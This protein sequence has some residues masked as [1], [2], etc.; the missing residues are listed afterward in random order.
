MGLNGSEFAW[1]LEACQVQDRGNQYDTSGILIFL[2]KAQ[3][4]RKTHVF[5][6]EDRCL[7]L[8]SQFS[9]HLLS[10]SVTQEVIKI[11]IA[12]GFF[13]VKWC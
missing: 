4:Y 9:K 10:C 2:F 13:T 11:I 8:H 6:M 5:K 3:S 7:Y 12:L 1:S